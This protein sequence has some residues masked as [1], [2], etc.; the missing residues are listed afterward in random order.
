MWDWA[1]LLDLHDTSAACDL[2]S[3][4]RICIWVSVGMRACGRY[5]LCVCWFSLLFFVSFIFFIEV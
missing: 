5:G 1:P 3:Q 2:E 4:A